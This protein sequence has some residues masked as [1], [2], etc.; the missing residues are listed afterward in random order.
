M[1]LSPCSFLN[2]FRGVPHI[3]GAFNRWTRHRLRLQLR[4]HH[5]VGFGRA[6]VRNRDSR[7]RHGSFGAS[8]AQYF[9]DHSVYH[10]P[11]SSA[12]RRSQ[13]ADGRSRSPPCPGKDC[14]THDSWRVWG[15]FLA[16]KAGI[17]R[18][19]LAAARSPRDYAGFR[20]VVAGALGTKSSD[21]PSALASRTTAMS[22]SLCFCRRKRHHK[23]TRPYTAL[24]C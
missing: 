5:G 4:R 22:I 13:A 1:V 9:L 15:V 11:P 19:L 3:L 6:H 24:S 2:S 10:Q 21:A 7:G 23:V 20:W 14:F 16:S 12:D 17:T 8:H 18:C